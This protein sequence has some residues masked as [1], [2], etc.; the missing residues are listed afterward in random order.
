MTEANW[1]EKA[2]C[3]CGSKDLELTGYFD[4]YDDV[5]ATGNGT[6]NCYQGYDFICNDCGGEGDYI[7]DEPKA[8]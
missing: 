4:A 3:K 1:R 2:E 5:D 6:G 7:E 8:K